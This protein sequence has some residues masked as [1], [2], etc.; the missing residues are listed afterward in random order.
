M[1]ARALLR[2][3]EDELHDVFD[4]MAD[5]PSPD[6][7]LQH[8]P[9]PGR[10]RRS[11]SGCVRPSPTT[12]WTRSSPFSPQPWSRPT[13]LRRDRRWAVPCSPAGTPRVS[14]IVASAAIVEL[15]TEPVSRVL[16]NSLVEALAV[17]LGAAE[18]PSGLLVAAR[19]LG[20][21]PGPGGGSSRPVD[22]A[23][24]PRPVG[25]RASSRTLPPRRGCLPARRRRSGG[26]RSRRFSKLHAPGPARRS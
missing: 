15:A 21:T 1:H 4:E 17:S 10:R 12:T 23:T 2:L 5:L 20:L 7:S 16:R 18:N 13:P 22:R 8:S 14:A 6:M 3:D 24:A 25:H 26:R 11:S 9:P 19:Q